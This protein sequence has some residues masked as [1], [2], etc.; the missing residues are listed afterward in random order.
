ML[1]SNLVEP[2]DKFKALTY[3]G[4]CLNNMTSEDQS[5]SLGDVVIWD[6]NGNE[7]TINTGYA[8]S[9]TN[10]G[11]QTMGDKNGIYVYG[12]SDTDIAEMYWQV[13]G[14]TFEYD[15]TVTYDEV[16][17]ADSP[18][19]SKTI[20]RTKTVYVEG[21]WVEAQPNL[22][23]PIERV[24]GFG[25]IRG[26]NDYFNDGYSVNVRGFD[27][28]S[29]SITA[30]K[31]DTYGNYYVIEPEFS[32]ILDSSEGFLGFLDGDNYYYKWDAVTNDGET[33]DRF[34]T[35][36]LEIIDSK[37]GNRTIDVIL[38]FGSYQEAFQSI[39]VSKMQVT[40]NYYTF[41]T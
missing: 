34:P 32:E 14:F 41:D 36:E 38:G 8:Q 21:S 9:T 11:K 33:G 15:F 23:L 17:K 16:W 40:V 37:N 28:A 12:L 25:T 20:N 6:E 29:N 5:S 35:V 39:S 24:C 10:D 31:D 26:R 22:Q 3:Y 13:K 7:S 18:S 30:G 27:N 2:I 19:I 4:G 1:L